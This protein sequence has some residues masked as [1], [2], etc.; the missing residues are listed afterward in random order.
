MDADLALSLVA[1][2]GMVVGA[3]CVLDVILR[4]LPVLA[5]ASQRLRRH[6][7]W[8]AL[9]ALYLGALLAA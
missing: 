3:G 8:A 5:P 1:I 4:P 7:L 2:A 9:V 6:A